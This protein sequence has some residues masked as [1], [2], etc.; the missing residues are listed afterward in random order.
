MSIKVCA[1]ELLDVASKF[2]TQLGKDEINDILAR[3]Q[4][5]IDKRSAPVVGEAGLNELIEEAQKISQG[6]KLNAALQKR[7]ALI[8]A[9]V[10]GTLKTALDSDADNP[11]KVLSS[12]M[13]GDA[14][15]GLYSVDAKGKAILG[16][17]AG[18]F[19]ADLKRSD[20]L[21]LFK[22]GELD[23]QIY[24]ELFDGLG[25]SGDAN[26]RKIAE[27]IRNMQK[28]GID[29]KNRAGANVGTLANYVV[30]Q[31]HDVL[32]MR[33]KGTLED[34][35]KWINFIKP[36]LDLE[37]TLEDMPARAK[38]GS[39]MNEEKF[40]GDIYDNL[41]SGDHR[42]TD[43]LY[44]ADGVES[45]LSA[46]RG[47]GNLAKKMS[48]ERV[49]HF[50]DGE[51]S[52]AYANEYSRQP[53]RDSVFSALSHDAQSIALLETFGTNPKNMFDMLLD[54][55][56]RPLKAQ[57]K[58]REKFSQRV[59]RNQ[60]AELDGTTRAIG[61]GT[62]ILGTSVTA[63]GIASGFRAVQAM[64]KLGF[65]TISSFSDIA[66][67]AAFINS[68]TDR[69]IFKS[70]GVAMRDTFRIFNSKEQK[71]LALLLNIGFENELA[72]IHARFSSNDSAPGAISR[73]QQVFFKL[74]G[75]QWWNST[76][77]VG[78]A[79]MLAADLA[80]YATKD[81]SNVP[82]STQRL[83]KL[84]GIT[85][86]EWPLFK[87][88]DMT[89]A[90]GNKYLTTDII[91]TLTDAAI[92]P[93]ISKQLGTT[94][95]TDNMRAT[96]KTELRTKISSYYTDSADTA[97]PTPGA[98]ERAIMNLGQPRG[99]VVGEALRMVM[100]LKGFPITYVTKGFG[101]QYVSGGKVGLAKMM[102]GTTMMGYLANATK[103]IL[104]GKEPMD[105]FDDETF[106][107]KSTLLRAF[108]QGGGL[109]IYGDFI[110]G[111]FNR[112][113][114]S[115]L[116]TFAGPSL[117][118]AGDVL[119]LFAKWRDGDDA[120][121]ES[122]RLMLR[123]TPY[124]NLFYSKLALDHLFLYELQEFASPGYFRRME[125]RMRDDTNQEFYIPPS[126]VVR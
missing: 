22:S 92:D 65:A 107:D 104:K 44:G 38:D 4:D 60:F 20:T 56:S 54:D 58:L 8:N 39:A 83:L 26:A 40:L 82:A 24:K 126:S 119:K 79:R 57:P 85:E 1:Q 106:I 32:L 123:N 45:R 27:A 86:L 6:A 121:A 75:M 49:L 78:V 64:S 19:L 120:A 91:D 5:K 17:T 30:R 12:I 102:V 113:G 96:F 16:D 112:Y 89:M 103:D 50:K 14:R 47:A 108:T 122:V 68:N 23:A 21:E 110:F 48:A 29:R 84:Y 59:L 53:L 3:V 95:I 81:F 117:G 116:E 114:Q 98:R 101:R 80:S 125:K 99:T 74:N 90:D 87:G 77:K 11:G 51:S 55:A 93:V 9:R 33:G 10:Y 73:A 35:N 7:N 115:P 62:P 25:E 13:V 52:F 67:K 71:E 2:G 42:K 70:Y 43:A 36:L 34:K 46:Y 88:L 28:T 63:A 72:E 94:A 100:Q 111:E 18:V 66:T 41:V 15:R 109:G 124:M 97:I 76:Q 31:A 61:A 69:N 118:T 105:V 37:K